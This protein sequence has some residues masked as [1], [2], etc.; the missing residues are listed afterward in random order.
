MWKVKAGIIG[1]VFWV[2]TTVITTRS[3]FTPGFV[4]DKHAQENMQNSCAHD[5]QI[6]DL[7]TQRN[8]LSWCNIPITIYNSPNSSIS[9]ETEDP[10]LWYNNEWVSCHFY[11]RTYNKS[12]QIQPEILPGASWQLIV[13]ICDIDPESSTTLNFEVQ[14]KKQEEFLCHTTTNAHQLVVAGVVTL[15]WKSVLLMTSEDRPDKQVSEFR[16]LIGATTWSVYMT[17]V[18]LEWKTLNEKLTVYLFTKKGEHPG[19]KELITQHLIKTWNTEI[20]HLPLEQQS[21][22]KTIITNNQRKW[23]PTILDC[24][25]GNCP[26]YIRHLNEKTNNFDHKLLNDPDLYWVDFLVFISD[27]T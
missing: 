18:R 24:P 27:P 25:R 13:D 12:Y 7:S 9:Y 2:I 1:V 19:I 6:A 3:W 21:V 17:S 15:T 23:V 26:I 4:S 16:Q 5:R 11:E 20:I 22:K 14:C 10:E 8:L